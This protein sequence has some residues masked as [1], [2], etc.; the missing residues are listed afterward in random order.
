MI[1]YVIVTSPSYVNHGVFTERAKNAIRPMWNV[2][3]IYIE[4]KEDEFAEDRKK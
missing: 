4:C 1:E 3:R 2:L